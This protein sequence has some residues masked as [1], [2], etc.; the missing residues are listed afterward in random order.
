MPIKFQNKMYFFNVH[1][2][3]D[4]TYYESPITGELILVTSLSSNQVHHTLIKH[5]QTYCITTD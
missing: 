1:P 4:Q 2:I 5:L 3:D